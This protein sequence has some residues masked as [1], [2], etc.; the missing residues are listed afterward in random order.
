MAN[1]FQSV[2]DAQ[3]EHF[4]ADATRSDDW[5]HLPGALRRHAGDRPVQRTDPAA[6]RA[7]VSFWT[8]SSVRWFQKDARFDHAFRERFLALH[9]DVAARRHDAWMAS[10]NGALALLILVDQFPRNAFRGTG[11]MY[12]TDPLARFYARQAL[13]AGHMEHVE[14]D[15]R[16]FFCLPFAH[17]EDL[18]DQEMSVALNGRLG[19]PWLAHALGHR[20]VIRRFGRFP[21]RNSMLGRITTSQEQA[22]LEGGGFRG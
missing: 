20:D 5:R 19:E 21:H 10:P 13:E 2:P 3:R 1:P 6:A 17:S 7:V 11:H 16:L 4:V 12:A 14:P 22:F 18:A 9:M 8:A 15:M